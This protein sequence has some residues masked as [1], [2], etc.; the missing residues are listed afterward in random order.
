M[1]QPRFCVLAG[2]KDEHR[3]GSRKFLNLGL[4][5]ASKSHHHQRCFECAD[6]PRWH[7]INTILE[8]VSPT[9]TYL[10]RPSSLS[11]SMERH[12]KSGPQHQH[13]MCHPVTAAQ[14]VR[15]P[16]CRRHRL[17]T[18]QRDAPCRSGPARTGPG[19]CIDRRVRPS[20]FSSEGMSL[21]LVVEILRFWGTTCFDPRHFRS[22]SDFD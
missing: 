2:S 10:S 12:I 19:G 13:N 17:R 18:K 4:V 11:S 22:M 20:F 7:R 9:N 21:L 15:I 6:P 1:V 16:P 14:M 5:P 8:H 3:H